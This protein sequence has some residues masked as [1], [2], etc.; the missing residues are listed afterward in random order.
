MFVDI[1]APLQR[2]YGAREKSAIVTLAVVKRFVVDMGN[3]L[4]FHTGNE[5]EY[6]NG[7]FVDYCNSLGIRR[8]FTT[9][10]TL[11]QNG[12]M[13][14]AMS[15]ALKAGLPARLEGPPLNPDFRLEEIR[16]CTDA[17]R[18][19]ES[20]EL[21]MWASKRFSRAAPRVNGKWQ[22]PNENFYRSSPR[23]TPP[24]EIVPRDCLCHFFNIGYNRGR[25]CYKVL[26]EA[27]GRDVY[28]HHVT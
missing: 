11:R 5:T 6:S 15:R 19:S 12:P 7:M 25:A 13:E 10:H 27:N 20:L 24:A 23:I 4:V 9:P 2:P 14:S 8:R 18:T 26:Q 3:P 16:D 1:F 21:H 17:T 22:S 28:S